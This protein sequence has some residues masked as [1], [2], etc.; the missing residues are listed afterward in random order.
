MNFI[1][2]AKYFKHH[3]TITNEDFA[4]LAIGGTHG[5][6]KQMLVDNGMDTDSPT[7]GAGVNVNTS[8]DIMGTTMLRCGK[9]KVKSLNTEEFWPSAPQAGKVVF[10]DIDISVF[11]GINYLLTTEGLGIDDDLLTWKIIV[12][13]K[14]GQAK[15]LKRT[16][17][18]DHGF[19]DLSFR[20]NIQPSAHN[21]VKIVI[22][23]V[24]LS[25]ANLSKEPDS[26]S[27]AFHPHP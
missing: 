3:K 1:E 18:K 5:A 7:V 12:K 8:G 26:G 22:G 10:E 23:A 4:R 11:S 21:L 9:V 16:S 27:R 24:P 25:L 14:A 19:G 13:N 17:L 6:Y 2:C 15:T 20:M